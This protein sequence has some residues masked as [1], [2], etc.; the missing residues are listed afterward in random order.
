MFTIYVF[1]ILP[2]YTTTMVLVYKGIF[3]G[4]RIWTVDWGNKKGEV[5][6]PAV[7]ITSDKRSGVDIV[8][9]KTSRTLV[10]LTTSGSGLEDHR[11][12]LKLM[13]T[14]SFPW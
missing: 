2:L 7:V 1:M 9:L 4:K 8:Y 5:N 6:G 13:I 12:Q 11:R 3:S 14:E 10:R